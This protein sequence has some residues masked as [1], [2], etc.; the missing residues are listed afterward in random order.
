[1]DTDWI[2]VFNG[3]SPFI[4]TNIHGLKDGNIAILLNSQQA[5]FVFE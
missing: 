1:V 2:A 4:F 3:F 5:M